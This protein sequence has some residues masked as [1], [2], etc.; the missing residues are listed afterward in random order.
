VT[1]SDAAGRN[2]T[3]AGGIC[4]GL[5]GAFFPQLGRDSQMTVRSRNRI[6]RMTGGKAGSNE[7]SSECRF[8]PDIRF[9]ND[10][11]VSMLVAKSYQSDWTVV[12]DSGKICLY[13]QSLMVEANAP[14]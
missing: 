11:D 2:V 13:D 7:C 14:C 5:A 9:R 12:K 3:A 1:V 6:G 8:R 4:G 10:F